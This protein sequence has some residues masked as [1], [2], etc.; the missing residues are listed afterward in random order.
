MITIKYFDIDDNEI[1]NLTEERE[2]SA[3]EVAR[4]VWSEIQTS[5]YKKSATIVSANE[6]YRVSPDGGLYDVDGMTWIIEE[7]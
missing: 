3:L 7:G 2:G 6:T 5:D 4:Q 1:T